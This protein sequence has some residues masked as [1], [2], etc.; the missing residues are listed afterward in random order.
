MPRQPLPPYRWPVR[1]IAD[2]SLDADEAYNVRLDR[3]FRPARLD[4]N[5]VPAYED[6]PIPADDHA[7]PEGLRGSLAADVPTGDWYSDREQVRY[8]LAT[9][10]SGRAFTSSDR[11][12]AES[13]TATVSRREEAPII[14]EAGD[15]VAPKVACVHE[16]IESI[17]P[18]TDTDLECVDRHTA[19]RRYYQENIMTRERTQMAVKGFILAQNFEKAA[20]TAKQWGWKRRRKRAMGDFFFVDHDGNTIAYSEC[21]WLTVQSLRDVHIY[22]GNGYKNDPSFR[23]SLI[24]RLRTR[25]AIIHGLG[26]AKKDGKFIL[27]NQ[28]CEAARIAA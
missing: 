19:R 3:Y 15:K 27:P 13:Y 14:R 18:I 1:Y 26:R 2:D 23:Q 5:T 20:E 24:A 28:E 25:G 11:I 9:D 16:T 4:P 10:F 8:F 22:L 7:V 17:H 6:S 12:D 21:T